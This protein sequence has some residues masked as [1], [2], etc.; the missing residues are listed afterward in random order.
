MAQ[1]IGVN[2]S[3]EEFKRVLFKSNFENMKKLEEDTGSFALK[4]H[5]PDFKFIRKGEIAEW[6]NILNNVDLHYIKGKAD[7]LMSRFG[8][9]D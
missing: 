2:L 1:L 4:K 6:K 7:Y 3:D 8:Y 9:T 5:D